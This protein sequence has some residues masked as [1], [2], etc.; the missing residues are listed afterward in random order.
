M[1]ELRRKYKEVLA[2]YKLESTMTD[3]YVEGNTDKVFIESFLK[4]KKCFRKVLPITSIDF[5]EIPDD[6]LEGLD[7]RSNKNKILILSKLLDEEVP[8]TKIKCIVDKDFDDFI[9]S[10]SNSKLVRT[11]FSSLES[12]LFCDEVVDKFLTIGIGEFPF[13]SN[14]VMAQLSSVLKF[15][16]CLRLFREINFRSA[17]LITIDSNLSINKQAGTINFDEKKYIK[18]FVEKNNLSKERK[19]LEAAFDS[20]MNTLKHDIRHY[21]HGHDFIEIFFLYINKIKNTANFKQE[22]FGRT[23]FLTVENSMIEKFPL[24]KDIII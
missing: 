24:F 23:L 21:I 14:F 8:Y 13:D 6:Y 11:D 3:L 20:L 2:F 10:L 9:Q 5:S 12:Y 16:F 22:N 7:M 17:Q 18:K 19:N 15:L 4:K 1:D